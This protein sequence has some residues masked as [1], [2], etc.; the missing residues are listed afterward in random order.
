MTRKESLFIEFEL[1][2]LP[3][4]DEENFIKLISTHTLYH[5]HIL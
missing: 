3:D 4:I 2:L 5:N 1:F